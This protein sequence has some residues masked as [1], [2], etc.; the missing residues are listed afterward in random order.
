MKF[1]RRQQLLYLLVLLLALFTCGREDQQ[2]TSPQPEQT[3]PAG[4]STEGVFI[5]VA[6]NPV[7]VRISETPRE[8]ERGLMFTESL[9]PDEGML[10]VFEREQILS[11]WMKNT[12]LPLSVAFID[13]EGRILEIRHMQPL[14]EEA[15]HTSRQ[16]A[17]YA[18][19]MNAGWFEKHGVRVGD[20]VE[21]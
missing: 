20:R 8:R 10:F 11:F 15:R 16:P 5:Q 21:F 3:P 19:E 6:G 1:R 13:G 14:D 18:L 12:P 2:E 7:W 9:P 17:L 4:S